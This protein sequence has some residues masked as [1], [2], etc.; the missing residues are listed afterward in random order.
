MYTALR[1]TIPASTSPAGTQKLVLRRSVK[2]LAH[3]TGHMFGLQHCI[4]YRCPMNGS[5]HLQEADARPL[6]LCPVDL[7]KLQW[8]IRFDVVERYRG[9]RDFYRQAGFK[10]EATWLDRRIQFLGKNAP[11]GKEP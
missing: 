3:E 8:S 4:W 6:H 11:I 9:L 10:D 1:A 2:V 7:R 5:N